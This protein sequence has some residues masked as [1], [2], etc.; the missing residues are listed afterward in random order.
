MPDTLKFSGELTILT[1][2]CG[3]AHAI[4]SDLRR[5]QLNEKDA[6]RTFSVWCPLGHEHV[7]AGKSRAERAEEHR[8]EAEA[9]ATHL[10]D[11]LDAEKRQHAATKGQLTK[12]R[13][14]AAA[15]LCPVQGCGRSFVQMARHLATVHPGHVHEDAVS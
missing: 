5:H 8:R 9:Y 7:P 4:P 2:W 10:R 6:G 15:A 3:I 1:C 12:T 11:Q 13:K 14:R